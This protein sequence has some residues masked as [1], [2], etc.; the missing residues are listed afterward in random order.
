MN[1]SRARFGHALLAVAAFGLAAIASCTPKFTAHDARVPAHQSQLNR[2][3]L[4]RIAAAEDT[5]RLDLAKA[6]LQAALK[7][8][9]VTDSHNDYEDFE[10]VVALM[11]G[12]ADLD[13][14]LLIGDFTNVGMIWEYDQAWKVMKNVRAPLVTVQGNHDAVGF[15]KDIYND[16]F[17]ATDFGFSVKGV[18]FV[19]WAN[20]K[21][22][23]ERTSHRFDALQRELAKPTDAQK[24]IVV[25]HIP[26]TESES[27]IYST[28]EKNE[29]HGILKSHN[30]TVSLH[31][32]LHARG[33][34]RVDGIDYVTVQRVRDV[35]YSILT[36][37]DGAA[38]F[39]HCTTGGC[40]STPEPTVSGDKWH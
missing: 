12:H 38:T 6:S 5:R 35:N 28:A 2:K 9:I 23:Y 14:V 16:M 17:G 40:E 11:N 31:G 15:G 39:E 19:V 37:K 25:S 34:Q 13:F 27:Q 4:R 32:H 10:K 29:F 33:R 20:A 26:P 22:E 18:R 1:R 30:A 24:T 36:V 3:S 8:G 21:L 7:V